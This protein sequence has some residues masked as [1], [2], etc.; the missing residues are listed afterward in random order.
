LFAA[1]PLTTAGDGDATGDSSGEDDV[2]STSG[3]SIS[4]RK[5]PAVDYELS[6]DASARSIMRSSLATAEEW[7]S[8]LPLRVMCTEQQE[9]KSV[10]L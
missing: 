5:A 4:W 3:D 10:L 1:F 2:A 8:A 9:I 7:A 6:E